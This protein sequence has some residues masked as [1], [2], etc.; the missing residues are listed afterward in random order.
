MLLSTA[1]LLPTAATASPESARTA[2]RQALQMLEKG[3]VRQARQALE[4]T[5]LL[6]PDHAGAWLDL[7]LVS[8]ELG[9]YQAALGYARHVL[10][11]SAPPEA[12]RIA[13]ERLINQLQ[14]SER[15]N[16]GSVSVAAG[17][18]SNANGGSSIDEI[19][20]TTD[21]GRLYLELA[22]S[23]RAEPAWFSQL[24]AHY[25]TRLA[26][27]VHTGP[28]YAFGASLKQF[29]DDQPLQYQLHGLASQE[30]DRWHF[31]VRAALAR[32]G[33]QLDYGR[34]GSWIEYELLPGIA[35]GASVDYY[36][37]WHLHELNKTSTTAYAL[38]QPTAS[39]QIK[40]TAGRDNARPNRAGGDQTR[41]TLSAVHGW[42]LPRGYLSARADLEWVEDSQG[43]NPLLEYNARR[44]LKRNTLEVHYVLP[45]GPG[46][47]LS[48]GLSGWDQRSNIDLF[49]NRGL[50]IQAGLEWV[51]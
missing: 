21:Y 1:V 25:Q 19:G 20:L 9:E 39:T 48:S 15:Q 16:A 44:T 51:F 5:V 24:S 41:T 38:W 35:L 6:N 40:L 33:E 31:G 50:S 18:T 36:H 23:A 8:A 45:V 43:Y 46:L 22:E 32:P 2:Y 11:F 4:R 14:Q 29:S 10:S 7:A 26:S 47:T 27:P 28:L 34:V 17:H 37:H 49:R 42:R 3:A 13:A 30:F 12:A